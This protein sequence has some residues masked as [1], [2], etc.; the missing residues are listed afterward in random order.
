MLLNEFFYSGRIPVDFV[1]YKARKSWIFLKKSNMFFEE[2]P[3]F[4]FKGQSFHRIP[5]QIF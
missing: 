2:E 5:E 3:Y 1:K 4:F